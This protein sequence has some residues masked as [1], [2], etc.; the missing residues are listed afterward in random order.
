MY[1]SMKYV[2]VLCIYLKNNIIIQYKE[3]VQYWKNSDFNAE[4][5]ANLILII[6]QQDHWIILSSHTVQGQQG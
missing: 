3:K 2:D 4:V 5:D 6:Y 1:F